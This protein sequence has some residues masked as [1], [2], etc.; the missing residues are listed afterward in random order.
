M[1]RRGVRVPQR[2]TNE[3]ASRVFAC[4]ISNR[5]IAGGSTEEACAAAC[6]KLREYVEREQNGESAAPGS[7]VRSAAFNALL[8]AKCLL[9]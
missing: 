5:L 6:D 3:S 8:A 1:R 4:G 9:C 7:A 2:G